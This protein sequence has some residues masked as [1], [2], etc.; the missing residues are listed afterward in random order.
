MIYGYGRVSTKDQN[1]ARQRYALKKFGCDK[2]YA[3]KRSGKTMKR[4][5]L[6]RLLA[7]LIPGDV[8]VFWHIDRLG[9][10]ARDLINLA[11]DLR[12]RGITIKSLTQKIDTTTSEGQCDFIEK[13]A[14]AQKEHAR[15]SM[16]TLDGLVVAR[17]NGSRFGRPLSLS[18]R[19][20]EIA[21][22]LRATD[23][24]SIRLIAKRIKSNPATVWRALH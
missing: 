19:K 22:T 6:Q 4:P 8:L 11:Y 12:D 1:L 20:R 3:E 14:E 24:L 17:K 13:C 2:I 7:K 18:A 16:R 10:D 21:R 5:Q 23:E 15:I 9:R